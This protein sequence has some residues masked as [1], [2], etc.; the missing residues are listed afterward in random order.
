MSDTDIVPIYVVWKSGTQ[1]LSFV[2]QI[3]KDM[4][5][6]VEHEYPE[7]DTIVG[8]GPKSLLAELNAEGTGL[9]ASQPS[10]VVYHV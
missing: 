2:V 7:V 8:K 1:D 6:V 4:G 10:N 9:T 3:V 5:M